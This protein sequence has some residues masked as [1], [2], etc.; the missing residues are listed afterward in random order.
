MG[1]RLVDAAIEFMTAHNED[2]RA[3]GG[4]ELEAVECQLLMLMAQRTRDTDA[5]PTYY[6]PRAAT[7]AALGIRDTEAGRKRVQRALGRLE[8]AGAIIRP[9]SYRRGFSAHY[10]LIYQGGRD[11]SPN[12]PQVWTP[13]IPLTDSKGDAKR[14]RVW[15]PDD[16]SMDAWHPPQEKEEKEEKGDARATSIEADPPPPPE[17]IPSTDPTPEVTSPFCAAHP[18]GTSARC[19]ACGDARRTHEAVQRRAREGTPGRRRRK[20]PVRLIPRDGRQVHADPHD[21]V[22]LPDGTCRD[23]EIRV[24]DLALELAG[25][26]A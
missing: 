25:A 10:R 2:A 14:P 9:D 12:N 1:Y 4:R 8:G 6:A 21:H 24:D 17:P 3:H 13:G 22:P 26:I 5:E 20:P 23:C 15:T 18:R 11:A 7:C 19:R 16:Q